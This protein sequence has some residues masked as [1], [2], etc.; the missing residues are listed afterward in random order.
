MSTINFLDPRN[1]GMKQ[2][3]SHRENAG[4]SQSDVAERM[5]CGQGR[6]SYLE[7]LDAQTLRLHTLAEYV[8]ALGGELRVT[9]WFPAKTKDRRS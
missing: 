4:I 1:P 7:G 5:D 9:V 3:R 2:L 6:V 8:E